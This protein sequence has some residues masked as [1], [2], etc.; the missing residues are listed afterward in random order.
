[1]TG[2]LGIYVGT[3]SGWMGVHDLTVHTNLSI[4]MR[5]ICSQRAVSGCITMYVLPCTAGT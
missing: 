2:P 3:L 1:M 5:R 4:S